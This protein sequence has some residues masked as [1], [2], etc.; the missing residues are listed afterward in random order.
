MEVVMKDQKR[1]SRHELYETGT[2]H[3]GT[4]GRMLN[5][6]PIDPS[7]L[8]FALCYPACY[9]EVFDPGYGPALGLD[10]RSFE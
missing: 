1:K 3:W 10:Q 9:S 7:P 6:L 5:R 8:N 2:H 4:K